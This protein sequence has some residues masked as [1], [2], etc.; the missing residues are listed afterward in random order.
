MSKVVVEVNKNGNESSA[1]LMRRFSRKIQESGIIPKVKSKRYNSRILS[2]LA[3][4]RGKLKKLARTKEFEKLY[5]LG[6]VSKGR[7]G[8]K[9]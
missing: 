9:K 1:N 2:K 5:K 6:K 3:Q 8:R 4:K 7:R